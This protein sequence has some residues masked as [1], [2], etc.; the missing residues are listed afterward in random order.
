MD[1]YVIILLLIKASSG[2]TGVFVI[3]VLLESLDVPSKPLTLDLL[4]KGLL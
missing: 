1:A 2:K 3:S 4:Q